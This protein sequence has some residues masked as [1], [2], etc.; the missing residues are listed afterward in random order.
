MLGRA[1][2]KTDPPLAKAETIS[3]AGSIS[4]IMY[5]T[6]LTEQLWPSHFSRITSILG[7]FNGSSASNVQ[8]KLMIW[9]LWADSIMIREFTP[10]RGEGTRAG[11]DCLYSDP[12]SQKEQYSFIGKYPLSTCK[13]QSSSDL[14]QFLLL[15]LF[16]CYYRSLTKRHQVLAIRTLVS[17]RN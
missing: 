10:W 11:D 2:S 5:L 16:D 17:C 6:H 4:P 1:S 15:G 8:I 12:A 7:W 14:A 13:Y 9:K 3:D